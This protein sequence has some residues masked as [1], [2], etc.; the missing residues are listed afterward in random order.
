[1]RLRRK[2]SVRPEPTS[3]SAH[4][5]LGECP[6]GRHVAMRGNSSGQQH[7]RQVRGACEFVAETDVPAA[8]MAQVERHG[9]LAAHGVGRATG[10]RSADGTRSGLEGYGGGGHEAHGGTQEGSVDYGHRA[11]RSPAF[12]MQRTGEPSFGGRSVPQDL[13]PGRRLRVAWLPR[14]QRACPSAG[15]DGGAT[16]P[17]ALADVNRFMRMKRLMI[18]LVAGNEPANA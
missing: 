16:L 5:A 8:G 10:R 17:A 3:S 9:D 14:L 4:P 18:L 6:V 15:L 11:S 13:A 7:H 12:A 1:M 2:S